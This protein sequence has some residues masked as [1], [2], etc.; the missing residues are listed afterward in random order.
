MAYCRGL[1]L[2]YHTAGY[3]DP[4]QSQTTQRAEYDRYEEGDKDD[5]SKRLKHSDCSLFREEYERAPTFVQY[6][7]L[8][9]RTAYN[10]CR[11]YSIPTSL[12]QHLLSVITPLKTI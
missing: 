6:L 2:S 4:D 10:H 3:G 5:R 8:N 12:A 11:H 9:I 1:G 7:G